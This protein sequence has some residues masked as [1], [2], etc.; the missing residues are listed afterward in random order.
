MS[1]KA[2]EPVAG[3]A[4]MRRRRGDVRDHELANGPGKLTIAMGITR[5]H[6]GADL[7]RGRLVVCDGTEEKFET[8]VSPRIGIRHNA[9]WPMRFY[10][11]GNTSVSRFQSSG[12]PGR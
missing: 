2:L 10:I 12:K 6:N 8:G 3:L 9:D 4:A 7:T 1:D 5:A 11:A